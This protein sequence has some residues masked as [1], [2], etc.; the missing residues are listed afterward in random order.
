MAAPP[1]KK[2]DAIRLRPFNIFNVQIV[3]YVVANKGS[4]HIVDDNLKFTFPA[5][6]QKRIGDCFRSGE[7]TTDAFALQ[8]KGGPINCSGL[9]YDKF[10]ILTKFSQSI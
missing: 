3:V 8:G 6:C 1:V 9:E 5:H 10:C 4:D 7:K 2:F